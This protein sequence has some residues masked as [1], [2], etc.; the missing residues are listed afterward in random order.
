MIRSLLLLNIAKNLVTYSRLFRKTNSKLIKKLEKRTL[1]VT[2]PFYLVRNELMRF[3]SL[4]TNSETRFLFNVSL[5]LFV[6][7]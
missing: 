4:Y 6:F 7:A 1:K 5:L 2:S 3:H